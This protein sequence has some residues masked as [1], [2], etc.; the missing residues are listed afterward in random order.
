MHIPTKCGWVYHLLQFG[1]SRIRTLVRGEIFW[2]HPDQPPRPPTH[3]PLQWVL[4][5]LPGG[6]AARAW[7]DLP[8]HSSAR[9]KYGQSYTSR[10]PLCML[11]ILWDSL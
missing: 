3:P 10:S 8:S 9:V 4:G 1:Q 7:L 2:T 6:K 11:G 5:L